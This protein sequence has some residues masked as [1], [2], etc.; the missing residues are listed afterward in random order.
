MQLLAGGEGEGLKQCLTLSMGACLCKSCSNMACLMLAVIKG[1]LCAVLYRA[2]TYDRLENFRFVC[3]L[4]NDSISDNNAGFC[5]PCSAGDNTV[6]GGGV[7][8]NRVACVSPRS[9]GS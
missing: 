4:G 8:H 6:Q 9:A 3:T 2:S 5:L 7:R 1:S